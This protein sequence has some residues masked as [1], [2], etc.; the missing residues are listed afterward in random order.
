LSRDSFHRD[1]HFPKTING[2]WR[3]GFR[4]RKPG[5]HTNQGRRIVMDE[6][7]RRFPYPEELETPP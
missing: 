6:E 7:E 3:I 1:A 4:R 2:E 5:K